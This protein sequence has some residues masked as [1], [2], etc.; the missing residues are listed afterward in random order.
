MTSTSFLYRFIELKH[1][2]NVFIYRTGIWH[3]LIKLIRKYKKSFVPYVLL[4]VFILSSQ[5][6]RAYLTF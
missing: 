3:G 4:L 1:N 2:N 5:W 6:Q